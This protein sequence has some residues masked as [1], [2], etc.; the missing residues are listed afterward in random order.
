MAR[1]FILLLS[2]LAVFNIA[3]PQAPSKKQIDA[4]KSEVLK[5]AKSQAAQLKKEIAQAK[6]NNEDPENIKD[7]EEQLG[8]M[9]K[10]VTVLEGTDLSANKVPKSLPPPKKTEPAYVS[11]FTAIVLKQSVTAPSKD[12][13]TDQLLWYTGK[14]IDANTLIT[15]S[16][17]LV[18]YNRQQHVVT[19]QTD[20][21]R[22]TNYYG[23]VNTLAQTRQMK[24]DFGGRMAGL[25][26]SFFMWPEIE[27]AY[28][29]YNYFKDRYYDLAKNSI[30]LNDVNIVDL[31]APPG[32]NTDRMIIVL[33]QDF[34][35]YLSQLQPVR[36][37]DLVLPPKRGDLCE[38]DPYARENYESYLDT[39]LM[40]FYAEELNILHRLREMYVHLDL[41][42][43]RGYTVPNMPGLKEEIIKGI[44]AIILRSSQ[45]LTKLQVR[46]QEPDIFVEE[47][48]VM[49][50]VAFQKLLIHNYEDVDEASTIMLKR[51]AWVEINSIKD[52]LKNNAVFETYMRDQLSHLN[53]NVVLD[54]SLYLSHEYNKKLLKPSY[55]INENFFQTWMEGLRKFNRFTLSINL[56]F[57]YLV[58][59]P[60]GERLWLADGGLES[61]KIVVS[62]GRSTCK[63]HLQ[64]SDVNQS[65]LRT[66]E[67]SFYIVMKVISGTKTL[68]LKPPRVFSYSG[69]GN[70]AMVFPNFEIRFC[71]TGEPDSVMMNKL[72]YTDA[73]TKA[74]MAVHPKP[75]F[76]KEYSLDMFQYVNKMFV[77]VLN[78]KANS[79]ELVAAAGRMMN[80]QSQIQLPNSTGDQNLDRL[81]MEYL[82]NEK[83]RS[84]QQSEIP[85][86]NSANTVI[87][88]NASNGSPVLIS[89]TYS[90]IDPNDP[91]RAFGVKMTR[92]MITIKVEHT[93]L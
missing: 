1:F 78:A 81:M 83:R 46:Y 51:D 14:K 8:V 13:S 67:D 20:K 58:E 53:Y 66:N 37:W 45:K 91:D 5:D 64:I 70:M 59:G 21:R 3:S 30:D 68:Y 40:E 71:S 36:T 47:G 86:A 41:D 26:N 82:G 25:M 11:P 33:E 39:W 23:L 32:P 16:G 2:A 28:N 85:I 4:Q 12:K 79:G 65:G 29:E 76:G 73:D 31:S 34:D 15:V 77:A 27:K 88:F 17:T 49:A 44:N 10:M 80:M 48:L 92:S 24:N 87:P 57:E 89:T 93:P 90:T 74:F 9:E 54:Y 18:R 35:M 72:R 43:Q 42:Q 6:A 69:P 75:D 50:T 56:D 22:D 55:S 84:L 38:C 61:K 52:D 7:L 63:W 62:L 60:D 19:V